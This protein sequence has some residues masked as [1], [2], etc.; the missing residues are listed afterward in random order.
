M[1]TIRL[2]MISMLMVTLGSLTSAQNDGLPPLI[3][4]ELFFD[5]PEIA[6]GQLSPD[7]SMISFIK[8]YKGVMN[9]WVKTIDEPF[10]SARPLTAD[11]ERPVRNYFWSRDGKFILYAQ[12]KGGDE[13][14]NIYAVNPT[15]KPLRG[16][17]VPPNRDLTNLKGVRV[18]I[19]ALPRTDPDAIYIGLNDRDKAWHDLYKMKLS[20]GE[21]T[22]I[23]QNSENDR[24]T[25]WIFDWDDKLR[26]ATRSNSDGSN[27]I[28]RVDD[29]GFTP[30]YSSS[31]FETAYPLAFD[32]NNSRVYIHTNKGEKVDRSQLI[33]L[34]P[35]TLK[36]EFVEE[37][38]DYR[39]DLGSV[40]FSEVTREIIYTTYESER[41]QIRWKIQ[42]YE[43]DYKI[44]RMQRRIRMLNLILPYLLQTSDS[45]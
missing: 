25:G 10:E 8:P 17:E 2:L 20:T 22:L 42:D 34:D 4:R 23:R 7:G 11:T 30:I 45:G 38:P 29:N 5:N 37:D 27:E 19:Y 21:H 6:G 32:K 36:E 41:E 3:D 35:E 28:L 14:F 24:I 40:I 39:V 1:K 18:Q 13:N 31:V 15:E 44:I 16:S 26:L 33:L 9:I 43:R 12:D